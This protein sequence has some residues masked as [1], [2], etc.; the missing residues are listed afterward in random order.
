METIVGLIV[1]VFLLLIAMEKG[2]NGF[3]GKTLLIVLILSF[4]WV[5]V[6]YAAG[7]ELKI[8][9]TADIGSQSQR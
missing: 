9:P 1:L 2:M 4:V 7:S 5:A 3:I 8:L 6:Q